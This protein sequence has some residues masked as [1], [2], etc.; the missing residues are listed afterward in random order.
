[1]RP[2][3]EHRWDLSPRDAIALQR[4]LAQRVIL[5]PPAGDFYSVAGID[6]GLKGP[7][8]RAAVVILSLPDLEEIEHIVVE[9]RL[10]FPY[11]PGLLSFREAPA[12]LEALSRLQ[13]DPDVL[14]F[15]GQGYAHPRRLG[16]ATHVGLILDWPSVGCAKSR[17]CGTYREPDTERGSFTWLYDGQEKIGAVVRTR[18]NV[19]P[20]FVSPGHR[21][22]F[23]KAINLVLNCGRGFRLPEP[24]RRAHRLASGS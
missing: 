23:D 2:V 8:V 24:T 10:A 15:D 6:V 19:K 4:E 16:L 14:M 21:M 3:F 17:L 5:K 9:Q 11:V 13:H 20:V 1:M 18:R 22:S 7:Y 12:I